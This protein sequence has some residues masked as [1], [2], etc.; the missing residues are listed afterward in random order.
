MDNDQVAHSKTCTTAT[1]LHERLRTAFALMWN[2]YCTTCNGLGG[3]V[4]YY[5][6]SPAG[7]SLGSGWME[8]FNPCPDCLEQ[9]KCPRCGVVSENGFADESGECPKCGWNADHADHH[10]R[11][12]LLSA[13]NIAVQCLVV[14]NM[15]AIPPAPECFCHEDAMSKVYDDYEFLYGDD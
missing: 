8:D 11:L 4:Y 6:P 1:M 10:S 15:S 5:D 9:G 13:D 12:L 7:I 14:D 2:D 3:S